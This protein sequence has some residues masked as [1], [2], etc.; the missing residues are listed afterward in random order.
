VHAVQTSAAEQ[1]G[2]APEQ[3]ALVV[4]PTHLFV[5]VSQTGVAPAQVV[6]SVHCTQAPAAEHAGVVALFAAHWVAAVQAVQTSAAEQIGV[7]PVHVALAVQ[8]THLFV[9]V[10]Q[11]G[12]APEQVV[13]SVHC[14][15]VPAAEHAG[16]VV[17]FAA[18]WLAAV[19]AA[20]VLAAVQI[21]VVVVH[22]E[23]E[24]QPT[25]VF[26]VV[27]QTEAPAAQVEL[28]MH[29]TH[30]P[31]AEQTAR[32]GSARV[33]HWL[34]A[35]QAVQVPLGAQRGA[36]AGH[37][38]LVRHPTQ[39]PVGEHSVRAGSASA[40]HWVEALQAVQAPAAQIGVL[41]RQ[42]AAVRQPTHL[43]VVVSQSG[44]APEQ[45]ELSEH[46]THAPAAEQAA[47]AGSTRAAHWGVVVQAVH[48][49]AAEHI[50]AV[51]GQVAL[52]W[53]C[54]V[55]TSGG[56]EVSNWPSTKT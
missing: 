17:L 12:V 43:F 8:P 24:T 38:A 1:I 40:A 25:Q 18:H 42:V 46:W 26:V 19:Q 44:V 30:A 4:Q 16:V 5:V 2:V 56:M 22:V 27:S 21:G 31:P 54:G 20:Q 39:V 9:V 33:A 6:L 47:R 52:V 29:W 53:H 36:A 50:G 28:S 37:V 55:E 51:A 48:L 7:A 49:P 45:V 41:A 11:T 13:L 32:V 35:A 34:E 23:L 15:H 3:V 10:S 14:T